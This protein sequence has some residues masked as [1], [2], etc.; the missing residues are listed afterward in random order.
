[1][2]DVRFAQRLNQFLDAA[3]KMRA[4]YF[5]KAYPD[6]QRD[7]PPLYAMEGSRYVRIVNDMGNQ[8]FA[9]CFV[10][11]QTGDVLKTDGWKK[12]AKHARS[13]IWDDDFGLSGLGPYGA[14]YLK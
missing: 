14:K 11:K 10:D 8:R 1:M 9:Y 2:L 4:D 7:E 13:N 6:M 5:K 12:P 3:S